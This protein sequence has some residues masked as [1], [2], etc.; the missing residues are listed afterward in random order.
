[1]KKICIKINSPSLGDTICATPSVRKLAKAYNR[2]LIVATAY[3]EIFKNNK[4]VEKTYSFEEIDRLAAESN[5]IELFDTFINF[6]NK[7]HNVIDIRQFHAVDLGFSLLPEEMECDYIPDIYIP[8]YDLPKDYICIHPATTWASRTYS[9]EKWQKLIDLCNDNG[10]PVV[11]V[12]KNAV[13]TGGTHINKTVHKL[14][15]RNGVDYSNAL[16]LSQTWHVINKSKLFLTMDSGLLHL[17]GTTDAHIVQLGS[18]INNKLRAPYR[19]KSQDY[20][21]KYISGPCDLFCASDLRY[22]V[23]EWNTI[24]QVP[25]LLNCLENKKEFECHPN[26]DVVFDYVKNN[27]IIEDKNKKICTFNPQP[28]IEILGS[29]KFDYKVFFIDDDTGVILFESDIGTNMWTTCN[30]RYF[31]NWKIIIHN[32]TLDTKES[33]FF[34]PTGKKVYI[35]NESPSLGDSIAWM[36]I[37][38]A[39]QKKYNC[40]LDYYTVKKHLFEKNYPNINFY[41]YNTDAKQSYYVGYNIGCFDINNS[42]VIKFNWR[43]VSLQDVAGR[44]LGVKNNNSITNLV[45]NKSNRIYK[46]K[47]VCIATQSTTQS[48]YW[49]LKNGWFKVVGYLQMKGYKVVCVDQHKVYGIENNWNECPINVDKFVGDKSLDEIFSIIN[50]CEFF[51]GLSSGLSW[52]SWALNKKVISISGSVADYYEFKTPYRIINKQVCHGCFNN[53]KYSFDS[54]NWLWCPENK[55]F[56][57]TKQISFE[58]VKETIDKCISDLT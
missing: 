55:N 20:K 29:D 15:I 41:D 40:K 39:F 6:E 54:G 49:N 51:I 37:V 27:Y 14:I 16:S 19:K 8:L 43:E 25:L 47:Y 9:A 33:I 23:K 58:I 24:R 57:C 2:P 36:P 42:S 53:P 10:I 17:A 1:M 50:D 12:G 32:K 5:D 3:P 26:P 38:D 13:E 46:E 4:Y 7:R 44:Q 18:S 48:R 30:I 22:A 31:V 35:I 45:F 56:E 21:Y 11:I 34:N 52:V 28:K